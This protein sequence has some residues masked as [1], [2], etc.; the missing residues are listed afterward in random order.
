M[1][2]RRPSDVSLARLLQLV[3]APF[4]PNNDH[5]DLD[6]KQEHQIINRVRMQE[7]NQGSRQVRPF[8]PPSYASASYGAGLEARAT[9]PPHQKGPRAPLL[10]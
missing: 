6:Q 7:Q 5:D 3:P 2:F 1:P 8:F 9:I 10:T 4:A